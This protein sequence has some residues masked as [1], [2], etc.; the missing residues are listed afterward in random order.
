MTYAKENI[1]IVKRKLVWRKT[2]GLYI[3]LGYGLRERNCI[4]IQAGTKDLSLLQ[5]VHM[6]FAAQNAS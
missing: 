3:T 4:R 5:K 6:G 2:N 1:T